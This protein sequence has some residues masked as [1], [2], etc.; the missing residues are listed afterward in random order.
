[1][2][3]SKIRKMFLLQRFIY[4]SEM[5]VSITCGIYKYFG[6]LLF[7]MKYNS[8]NW[9]QFHVNYLI[10]SY[11]RNFYRTRMSK[12]SLHMILFSS[13]IFDNFFVCQQRIYNSSRSYFVF[14][15][16]KLSGK[17]VEIN[18]MTCFFHYCDFKSFLHQFTS[19]KVEPI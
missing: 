17:I 12:Y 4:L 16:T 1:M 9:N 19:L 8:K 5:R 10:I 18:S 15:I 13:F 14:F 2:Y 7:F 6:F 3:L 11:G